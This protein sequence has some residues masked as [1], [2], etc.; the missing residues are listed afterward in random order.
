[1][2]HYSEYPPPPGIF[3][4]SRTSP[5]RLLRGERSGPCEEVVVMIIVPTEFM[6]I[7]CH[8]NPIINDI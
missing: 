3:I 1:M 2:G 7:L 4:Y 5:Q 6:A 8:G